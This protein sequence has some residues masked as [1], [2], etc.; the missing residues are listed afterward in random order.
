M[1]DFLKRRLDFINA[2]RPLPE[3]KK[4]SIPKVSEK[5]KKKM[6][7]EK[8]TVTGKAATKIELD[9][10]FYNIAQKHWVNGRCKCMECGEEIPVSYSRHATAHLFPKKLFKSIATHELNYMVLGAG[11]GCHYK[12][13]R[14]DKIVTL[15]VW[16]EIARR[17]KIMLP[18]LPFDELK[19]VSSELLVALDNTD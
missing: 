10:W 14:V 6:E 5:R 8:K 12:T 7:E 13:D 3:K 2:G 15:K 4:Y 19:H 9:N 18:I 16:P 1:N 11:C 17:M